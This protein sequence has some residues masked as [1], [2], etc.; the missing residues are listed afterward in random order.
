VNR[1]STNRCVSRK[2]CIGGP[3]LLIAASAWS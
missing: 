1:R 2:T 3:L